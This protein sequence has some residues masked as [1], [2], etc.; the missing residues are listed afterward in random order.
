M[1]LQ[2]L[3][4]FREVAT[5]RSFT[6]AAR[7]LHY[8]QSSVTTQIKNL[9]E[10]IGAVLFDRTHRQVSLTEAGIR[11]LPYA[12]EIIRMVDRARREVAQETPREMAA[13]L[14]LNS[15]GRASAS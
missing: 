3:R 9:E 11:L 12:D 2:Q 13:M 15:F 4:T 8:A 6:R 7:N 14:S 10:S 1:L 5:E